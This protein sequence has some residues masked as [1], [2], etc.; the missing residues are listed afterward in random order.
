[1]RARVERRQLRGGTC[2]ETERRLRKRRRT[3][4]RRRLARREAG[5]GY[6]A[7]DKRPPRR[8]SR[9]GGV[10]EQPNRAEDD[11]DVASR[12]LTSAADRRSS[13]ARPRRFRSSWNRGSARGAGAEKSEAARCLGRRAKIAEE[14]AEEKLYREMTARQDARLAGEDAKGGRRSRAGALPTSRGERASQS[15]VGSHLLRSAHQRGELVRDER[16]EPESR[17]A[18][19]TRRVAE[20]RGTGT[21]RSASSPRACSR[22]ERSRRGGRRRGPSRRGA[23]RDQRVPGSFREIEA[24]R[25]DIA[26]RT[27]RKREMGSRLA[28]RDA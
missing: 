25:A 7:R 8:T 5:W 9:R 23:V 10:G 1:M 16:V 13:T 28:E 19:R 2:G 18:P 6:G 11:G 14:A 15:A 12:M 22:V 21:E 24:G 17:S 3:R 4:R 27:A 20:T 26:D